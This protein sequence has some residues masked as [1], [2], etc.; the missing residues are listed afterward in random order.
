MRKDLDKEKCIVSTFQ[1]NEIGAKKIKLNSLLVDGDFNHL[2]ADG[3]I[4]NNFFNQYAV[5]ID[6]P[7]K[8]LFIKD[9]A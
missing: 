4:G 8:R 6:F 3:L 2:N 7:G 5:L 9:N 1:L